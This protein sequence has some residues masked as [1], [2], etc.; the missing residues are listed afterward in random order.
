[1]VVEA[2]ERAN[3][4]PVLHGLHALDVRDKHQLLIV[5][6][7]VANLTGSTLNPL[8]GGDGA[9]NVHLPGGGT[10]RMVLGFGASII[11]TAPD[12]ED[13]LKVAKPF[14][15]R[16]LP[17]TQEEAS[18]QPVFLMIFG[19]GQAFDDRAVLATLQEA[20]TAVRAALDQVIIGY[21]DP[22]N[23]VH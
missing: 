12:H 3:T 19:K 10:A 11:M 15:L 22:A 7:G 20:T 6:R 2:I 17:D 16:D 21:L 4:N 14:L 5:S 1:M 9:I 23:K 13:I 18:I 8:V